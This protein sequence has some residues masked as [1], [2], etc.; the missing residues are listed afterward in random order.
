MSLEYWIAFAKAS[1]AEHRNPG[2]ALA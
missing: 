2:E 1:A